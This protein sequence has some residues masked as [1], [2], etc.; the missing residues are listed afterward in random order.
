MGLSGQIHASAVWTPGSNHGTGAS[1]AL[2]GGLDVSDK[3]IY[4]A[5]A[6]IRAPVSSSSELSRYTDWAAP[7]ELTVCRQ[8]IFKNKRVSSGK[9]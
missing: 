3:E 1:W 9:T 5:C 6:K 8:N 2:R 7:A 4:L